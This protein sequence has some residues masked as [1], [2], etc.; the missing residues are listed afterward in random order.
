MKISQ[1]TERLNLSQVSP[2]PEPPPDIGNVLI[3]LLRNELSPELRDRAATGLTY[4]LKESGLL[5]EAS[6]TL[7][8]EQIRLLESRKFSHGSVRFN[9]RLSRY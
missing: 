7:Q 3:D 1:T 4:L 9:D 5:G 8:K 6:K 2:R